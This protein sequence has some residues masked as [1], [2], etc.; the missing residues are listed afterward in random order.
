MRFPK[1][2]AF[3]VLG[4]LYFG[5]RHKGTNS[6]KGKLQKM[7]EKKVFLHFFGGKGGKKVNFTKNGFFCYENCKTLFVF[8]RGKSAF[9]STLLLWENYPFCCL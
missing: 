6:K 8:G 3:F 1:E 5:E 4:L 2:M 9:S 7:P